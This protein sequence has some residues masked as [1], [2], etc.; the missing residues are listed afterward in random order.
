VT[1]LLLQRPQPSR[2]PI[3][4]LGKA[5]KPNLEPR[6]GEGDPAPA[7]G[8]RRFGGPPPASCGGRWDQ[9]GDRTRRPDSLVSRYGCLRIR[10]N[11][12]RRGLRAPLRRLSRPPRLTGCVERHLPDLSDALLGGARDCLRRLDT[13]LELAQRRHGAARQGPVLRV[14]PLRSLDSPNLGGR[15]AAKTEPSLRDE[16]GETV[17]GEGAL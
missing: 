7:G 10:P 2:N 15:E 3:G 4:S 17:V 6:L 8:W 11:N 1:P 14:V 13:R 12:L 9:I 5:A 16:K